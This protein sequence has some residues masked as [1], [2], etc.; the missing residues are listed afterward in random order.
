V[1]AAALTLGAVA[2]AASESDPAEPAEAILA[3][4][5][6]GAVAVG[7]NL[8][9]VLRLRKLERSAQDQVALDALYQAIDDHLSREME[10]MTAPQAGD[11]GRSV[12]DAPEQRGDA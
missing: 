3:V 10:A 1:T 2:E 8:L 6:F 11:K 12:A 9:A 5:I 4:A 7:I